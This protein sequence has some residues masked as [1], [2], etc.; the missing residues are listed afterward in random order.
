LVVHEDPLIAVEGCTILKEGGVGEWMTTQ[1][2]G[3]IHACI[4]KL[5]LFDTPLII[6]IFSVVCEDIQA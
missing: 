2:T 3:G 4:L 5:A 6:E 1:E